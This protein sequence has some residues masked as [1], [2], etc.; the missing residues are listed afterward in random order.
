MFLYVEMSYRS[1]G[2]KAYCVLQDILT[3]AVLNNSQ[4]SSSDMLISLGNHSLS[5]CTVTAVS[6]QMCIFLSCSCNVVAWIFTV[7]SAS[8]W[9]AHVMLL[10]GIFTM[11]SVSFYCSCNV[12]AWNFYRNFFLIMVSVIVVSC[13]T[14][15]VRKALYLVYFYHC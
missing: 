12:L 5:S 11:V 8:F 1:T 4:S 15:H 9:L 2:N 7:V 13:R 10:H 3:N 14:C 6:D